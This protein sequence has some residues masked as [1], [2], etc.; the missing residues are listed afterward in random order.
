MLVCAIP[1]SELPAVEII[2]FDKLVH[3]GVFLLFAVL[4]SVRERPAP[5]AILIAGG[6]SVAVFTE[7]M[8]GFAIPGR[9]SDP[10]D[11]V[12]D[13]IGLVAGAAWI[14][15]KKKRAQAV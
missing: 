3:I 2:A 5:L 8:Q 7:L 13:V 1:G 6:V 15:A 10:Y 4:W 9:T 12:A 14:A 11:V